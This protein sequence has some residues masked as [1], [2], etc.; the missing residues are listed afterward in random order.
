MSDSNIDL[1]NRLVECTK[2]IAD[3]WGLIIEENVS[4][5][6]SQEDCTLLF[7]SQDQEVCARMHAELLPGN[8]VLLKVE[9][10]GPYRTMHFCASDYTEDQSNLVT[11]T[12]RLASKLIAT[13]FTPI[14]RPNKE[15]PN[16]CQ[17]PVATSTIICN[18]LL[19]CFLHTTNICLTHKQIT[20][21]NIPV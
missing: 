13:I 4:G 8:R 19:V 21:K 9:F 7:T 12:E 10:G 11:F 1:L 15:Y 3:E 20:F 14:F 17:L 16:V 6:H 18:Y 5:K 2:K